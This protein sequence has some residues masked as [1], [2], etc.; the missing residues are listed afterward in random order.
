[1]VFV[2]KKLASY[3]SSVQPKGQISLL[4]HIFYIQLSLSWSVSCLKLSRKCTVDLSKLFESVRLNHH[5]KVSDL[6]SKM[7]SWEMFKCSVEVCVCG[8]GTAESDDNS[9]NLS[10]WATPFI[11]RWSCMWFII[12]TKIFIRPVVMVTVT[13]YWIYDTL[14]WNHQQTLSDILFWSRD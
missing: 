9:L 5:S 11:D 10:P 4:C 8:G 7:S 2:C 13:L 3:T 14:N 12:N 1:M 6:Q